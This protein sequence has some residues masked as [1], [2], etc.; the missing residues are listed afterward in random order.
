MAVGE[1]PELED[2]GGYTVHATD[3]EVGK[4]GRDDLDTGDRYLLIATGPWIFGR[5]VLLPATVI[6]H[7]DHRNQAVHLKCTRDAIRDAPEYREDRS[8]RD[9]LDVWT[10]SHWGSAGAAAGPDGLRGRRRRHGSVP[11][12]PSVSTPSRAGARPPEGATSRPGAIPAPV[13]LVSPPAQALEQWRRLCRPL[14][15]GRSARAR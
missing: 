10:G 9:E 1:P 13:P 7:V 15:I 4:V 12:R 8:H 5:T 14:S 2:L 3:G 11:G 6:D